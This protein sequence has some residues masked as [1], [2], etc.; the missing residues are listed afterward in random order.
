MVETVRIFHCRKT[1]KIILYIIR[2]DNTRGAYGTWHSFAFAHRQPVTIS[3]AS[4]SQRCDISSICQVNWMWRRRR[5][6]YHFLLHRRDQ[7]VMCAWFELT[8]EC[9]HNVMPYSQLCQRVRHPAHG[10]ETY[11]L[12]DITNW[13]GADIKSLEDEVTG[14]SGGENRESLKMISNTM[15]WCSSCFYFFSRFIWF[16]CSV[17]GGAVVHSFANHREF[18]LRKIYLTMS[19][20]EV[21]ALRGMLHTHTHTHVEKMRIFWGAQVAQ[22]AHARDLRSFIVYVPTILFFFSSTLTHC[23]KW[24]GIWKSCR[25]TR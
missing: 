10:I 16:E 1:A 11:T 9:T 18:I 15:T 7:N 3:Y 12:R 22:V 25:D 2:G 8:N 21:H 14:M 19:P 20:F 23:V 6:K 17:D 24:Y 13:C 4:T 5:K